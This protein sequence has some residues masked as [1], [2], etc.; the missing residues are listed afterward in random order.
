MII[1]ICH[2][3]VLIVRMPTPVQHLV[4]AQSLLD[5]ASLPN[6]IRDPLRAQ[7]GAFLF[8]NTAPDVQTVSGQRREA[9]HF[10]VIPWLRVP[11][12]HNALFKRYPYLGHPLDLPAAQAA[13]IAGYICHLWLDVVW[14]RDIY[15]DNFGPKAH[16]GANLRERHVYHNIL[17]AWCDRHDQQQLNGTLGSALALA[18]PLEWL[19]FTADRYLIQWRDN[20]AAQFRPGASIRT[21]EVFAERGGVPPEKFQEVLDSPAEME[22]H[23]FAHAS[24]AKIEKF[25]RDGYEQMAELLVGYFRAKSSLR[26]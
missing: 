11:A 1:C 3:S 15:L 12:P 16:W 20:L 23:I 14:V 21:V 19:P 5:D 18:R 10:F 17:R 2:Y 13:F 22:Q 4:L 9:T 7:R 6:A 24:R 8:G 26:R 25:Y